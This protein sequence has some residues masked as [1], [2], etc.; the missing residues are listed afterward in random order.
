MAELE[1]F[2]HK[3]HYRTF[4]KIWPHVHEQFP[5]VT[6]QQV[7]DIIKNFVKDPHKLKQEKYYVPIFSDHPH[8]WMMD[9]LDNAGQTPEYNNKAE[10]EAK[11]MSK[12]YPLYWY[13]FININ[14]R[15][16]VAYPLMHKDTEH[17]LAKLRKF[18]SD[19]KCSSL[20]SDKESAFI[21]KR[22]S[23]YL[24]SQ[25]ISQFI[26]LEHNHTSLS[27]IDSFIR[28]L[29]DRNITNE[30]SKYESHHSKYRNFSTK[31]MQQLLDI[32]NNTVHAATNLKPIDMQN[33]IKLERQYIA[34]CL[35]KKS[36]S[37]THDIP[38]NNYVRIVLAKDIMKKRR[39]KV[40]RECYKVTGREGKNY[41]ISAFDNTTIT[42]PR[43][44]LIDLGGHKPE[45]Y[46]LATTI[47][48]AMPLVK[49][50]ISKNNT[51]GYLVNYGDNIGAG[52]IRKV[53]I[54]RHHPQIESKAEK[55]FKA[56]T[57]I[58]L[59][60]PTDDST[61]IRLRLNQNN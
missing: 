21:D 61:V 42:L 53:D 14:T 39:F 30:K 25:Y 11:E 40:S 26:V 38:V 54:R 24:K 29:R 46:K 58:R 45:K 17:I 56:R 8:A 47:P 15:F 16:V 43:H 2:I 35:I 36:K 33:D 37:K 5:D 3:L 1:R 7:K 12:Q 6:E 44:R 31:R 19:Y 22:T 60:L 32:Y 13:I 27:V 20:T 41:L 9:L 28:H 52:N 18:I 50:I 51:G 57:T 59:R 4:N 49:S 34:Y 23:N 48:N 10:V 55:D